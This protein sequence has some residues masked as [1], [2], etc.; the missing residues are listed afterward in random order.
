MDYIDNI[1]SQ[2]GFGE[3][4]SLGG[5]ISKVKDTEPNHQAY[6]ECYAY[7]MREEVAMENEKLLMHIEVAKIRATGE[8]IKD[9]ANKVKDTVK[10]G[11]ENVKKALVTMYE[12]AI[13]FFTET[14][15]YF[16]SNEKK[17]S[18]MMAKIKAALKKT[19]K[20]DSKEISV[21][22]VTVNDISLPDED[23]KKE[24]MDL[25]EI[26][27]LL[28]KETEFDS[29]ELSDRTQKFIETIKSLLE[30]QKQ[31]FENSLED[32]KKVKFSNYTEAHNY[33]RKILRAGDDR[34]GTFKNVKG[35]GMMKYINKQIR[36]TQ[37]DLKK[38]K[39]DFKENKSS[40]D[41]NETKRFQGER[42]RMINMIKVLN[43]MKGAFD[44]QIGRVLKQLNAV[45]IDYDKVSK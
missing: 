33:L 36:K 20:E 29:E 26:L 21:V 13:R 32:S 19:A 42:S 7:A 27:D 44:T 9:I 34:I 25:F 11:A 35:I 24:N 3:S 18:S 10:E 2:Y 43:F 37:E 38:L 4:V 45:L 39:K 17:I 22:G 15:K 28:S 23:E 31:D 40:S 6:A 12:K 5:G 41:E 30:E 8:G 16:F 14:V 1:L